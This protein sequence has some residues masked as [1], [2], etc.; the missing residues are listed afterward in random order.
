MRVIADIEELG[1]HRVV[2]VTEDMSQM[3]CH[4]ED[5]GGHT[6]R[7]TLRFPP[8]YPAQPPQVS[9]PALAYGIYHSVNPFRLV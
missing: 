6:H 9:P 2:D 1:W 8:D 3:T 5:P 4:L 7:L